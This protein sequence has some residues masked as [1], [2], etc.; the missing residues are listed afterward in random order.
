MCYTCETGYLDW[1]SAVSSPLIYFTCSTRGVFIT[2]LYYLHPYTLPAVTMWNY[3]AN[4]TQAP[5]MRVILSFL[6]IAYYLFTLNTNFL[7]YVMT[8]SVRTFLRKMIANESFCIFIN[9][10]RACVRVIV[11]TLSAYVCRH[12]LSDLNDDFVLSLQMGIAAQFKGLI[13]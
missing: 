2:T 13:A 7:L 3:H 12:T 4:H 6:P 11:V 8:S 10:Q 1:I 9:S 5:S